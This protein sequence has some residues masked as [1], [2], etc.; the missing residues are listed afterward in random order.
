VDEFVQEYGWPG[1]KAVAEHPFHHVYVSDP[2]KIEPYRP[3]L[4]IGTY[5]WKYDPKP[6]LLAIKKGVDFI[7]T[8]P[9]YG[10]GK[11]EERLKDVL[12]GK[13]LEVVIGSKF[14]RNRMSFN[15]VVSS[16]RRTAK[17]FTTLPI[18]LQLHWPNIKYP[19]P[20]ALRAMRYLFKNGEVAS[21]GVCNMS[22]P[23]LRV[24]RSLAPISTVQG[25]LSVFVPQAKD[26]L[27]PY[28]EKEGLTFLAYGPLGQEPKKL[29]QERDP[30]GFFKRKARELNCEVSQVLLAWVWAQGAVPMPATNKVEHMRSNL[31]AQQVDMPPDI[32]QEINDFMEKAGAVR[33]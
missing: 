21:L 31:D 17:R 15:N 14:A 3:Q 7:D 11:V 16:C 32:V 22:V 13:K 12:T 28:C 4:A 1:L 8:A 30:K 20:E 2:V 18:H 33:S 10:Y 25:P 29:L 5:R 6:I 26:F 27:L 23:L 9:T 19:L 24:A